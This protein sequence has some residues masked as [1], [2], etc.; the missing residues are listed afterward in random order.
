M[1]RFNKGLRQPQ[2]NHEAV[3]SLL[4]AFGLQFKKYR[5]PAEMVAFPEFDKLPK[6]QPQTSLELEQKNTF[7]YLRQQ[8]QDGKLSSDDVVNA[9]NGHGKKV[10]GVGQLRLKATEAQYLAKTYNES[11]LVQES[12]HLSPEPFFRVWNVANPEEKQQLVP[13]FWKKIQA[14]PESPEKDEM[15]KSIFSYTDNLDQ[16]SRNKLPQAVEKENDE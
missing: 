6:A 4:S 12:R 9:I 15:L 10:F 3:G 7:K 8:Y 5:T 2:D 11:Q 14:T 13:L 1:A 16:Q